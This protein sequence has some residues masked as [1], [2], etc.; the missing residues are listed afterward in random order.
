MHAFQRLFDPRAIAVV[1]AT[2]DPARTGGQ[3]VA[4]LRNNG[5]GGRVFPVNPRVREVAGF[6]CHPSLEKIHEAIDVAVIALP[7][8]AVIDVVAQCGELGIPFAVVLGAGFR[9]AG[10]E[11]RAR[12]DALVATAREHGVRLIGPNCL[13]VANVHS[14]AFAAFGSLTREPLLAPGPVSMVMQSGGFGNTLAFRCREAG[15]GFRLMIASGNEADLTAPELID[16]LIDDPQTRL[17][18]AYLEG[19]TDGRALMDVGVRALAAGKPLLVWKAGNSRQ[20]ARV[21]A[22]HTANLTGSH[23]IWRAAFHQSGIVEIADT[24]QAADAIRAL[25]AGRLPR[26]RGVAV[27]TPSGGSA[28]A[29]S[30]AADAHDLTLAAFAPQTVAVLERDAKGAASLVNPV[31]MAAGGIYERKDGAYRRVI[32]ALI[33]DPGVHQFCSMFATVIEPAAGACATVLAEA[34][35]QT[36]KPVLVFSSVPHECAPKAFEVLAAANIPVF[37]SPTRMAAAAG[38]L[39]GYAEARTRVAGAAW[40][41]PA[42]APGDAGV[43]IL[44]ARAGALDE[45]ASKAILAARGIPVTR[46]VVVPPGGDAVAAASALA[47]P[48]VAKVVSADIPHKSDIGGVVLGIDGPAALREA[49]ARVVANARAAQPDARIEGVLVGEMVTD[50][51]E[52][53]VGVVNDAVFGPTVMLGIGGVLTEAVRDTVVRVAPFDLA[54]AREMIAGLRARRVFD[55][56]RGRPAVDVEALA[57]ALVR[58]SELAWFSRDRI[59][60]LDVN[61]LLVRPK[62]LGVVAADALVVLRAEAQELRGATPRGR[63]TP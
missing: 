22:T 40:R 56:L 18:Y 13:G 19:V 6:R 31:D 24:E 14:R 49:A 3:A 51:V 15:I 61:P 58:I 28:V 46:D 44:P 41:A 63:R 5:F 32:D 25:L 45:A 21:A 55:G 60:G 43:A 33:A 35:A 37:T 36:D 47:F 54:T 10:P 8:A 59:E 53:I 34:A 16:A 42:G 11:G 30:D 9:E 52:A 2:E 26:G 29:F 57:D 50:A 7:A 48:L 4:A 39:A 62:G 12:E 23:D 20:G 38:V 1:G 27:L 17:I